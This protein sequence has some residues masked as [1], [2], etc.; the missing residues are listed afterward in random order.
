MAERVERRLTTILAADIAEYS[1]L[2]R[3]DEDATL[4]LLTRCRD[5]AAARI[6]AH[7]GRIANTA[8]DAV[9]AE[10]PSVADGVACALAIQ[11]AVGEEN[12]ALPSDRRMLFRI[13]VHL[14]DV[15]VRDGDLF[16]DA[17]N[18]AAR[19]QALAEPGGICVSVAVREHVGSRVSAAFTDAGA[20]QVKNIAEPVHVFRVAASGAAPL[21]EASVPLTLPDKPS[22]AVLPFTNMSSDAEQEFFADGIAE[23]VITALSRYPSLFVIA[24]NSSFTYKGRAVDVK[25][26]GRELGVRYVLEGGLRTSGNRIRV[27]AQLVEAETGKHVW[28]ERYDRDLADIFAVQDEITE[29]VTMAVAPAVADAELHRAMRKPPGSLDAWGASQRGLWHLSKFSADDHTL[30]PR[31]FQQAINLDPD[32][33]GGYTG[34]AYAQHRA[35]TR[36]GLAETESVELARRA[37]GLDANDAEA[38]VCLGFML[39]WQ[40]DLEG[41]LT[42]GEAALALSP[43]LAS[44]HGVIGSG[45]NWASHHEKARISL[46]KS[47]RLDPRNPNLLIRF[48]AIIVSFYLAGEY[49]AAIEVAKP[50]IRS[51]PDYA[52]NYRWL[53]A[54]LGQVG[55]IEEAKEAL[56]NAIAIAPGSF[57]M[58]V[59]T[60]MPWHR[61]E[62]HAHMLEGLRK[63][64]WRE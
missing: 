9:L 34:L 46:E 10:F 62:H 7:R 42:E 13:G 21:P 35:A 63:A 56:A 54:A 32:F 36:R 38:R 6:A 41:A 29:A 17:V 5:L 45:L 44:A 15:M 8:G 31:F 18:V 19:L 20:Q 43:N 22:V 39:L 1:R 33:A 2:M 25:Q 24:R 49:D 14:G 53:A 26:V 55:Q 51:Y 16:G 30:A 61:P 12:A 27:T 48:N 58:Y 60:R 40:G 50:T 4:A 47:I 59:R 37:V 52:S 11:E 64:G 23:D 3:A 28:A 57:D